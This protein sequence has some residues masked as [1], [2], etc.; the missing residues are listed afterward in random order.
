MLLP[1]PLSLHKPDLNNRGMDPTEILA[2]GNK[3]TG[4]N[5]ARGRYVVFH[6]A[7]WICVPVGGRA[8][9]DGESCLCSGLGRRMQGDLLLDLEACNSSQGELT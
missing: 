2:S 6:P 5:L 7:A 8:G 3:N 1:S 4:Y 9:G